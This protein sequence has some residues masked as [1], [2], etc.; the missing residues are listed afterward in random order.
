MAGKDSSFYYSNESGTIPI[1]T[2]KPISNSSREIRNNILREYFGYT[3]AD[4][5][6]LKRQTSDKFYYIVNNDEK[7][8]ATVEQ[9]R[10]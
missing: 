6:E 3:D 1:F 5:E 4:I 2:K 10:M 8:W 7:E 9:V